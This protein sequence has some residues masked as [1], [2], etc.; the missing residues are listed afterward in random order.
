[1][2]HDSEWHMKVTYTRFNVKQPAQL[3]AFTLFASLAYTFQSGEKVL[4]RRGLWTS[5]C[6]FFRVAVLLSGLLMMWFVYRSRHFSHLM[7]YRRVKHQGVAALAAISK[8]FGLGCLNRRFGRSGRCG[9]S[10]WHQC[11]YLDLRP[12]EDLKHGWHRTFRWWRGLR[13]HTRVLQML[14]C[15]R[16]LQANSGRHLGERFF[17]HA[18]IEDPR[19]FNVPQDLTRRPYIHTLSCHKVGD[20][21]LSS[22]NHESRKWVSPILV[23]FHLG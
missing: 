3:Q 23:S 5:L 8:G 12:A 20:K 13:C 11:Y 2:K 21:F 6:L 9:R 17:L 10:G 15:Y 14:S 16:P 1:M 7:S 19:I 18:Q 4:N 22:H